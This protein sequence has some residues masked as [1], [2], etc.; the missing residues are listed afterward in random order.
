[1][2]ARLYSIHDS[3]V[4]IYLPPMAFRTHGEAERD[5]VSKVN[6]PDFGHLHKS[7]GNF[8]LFHVGTWDDESGVMTRAEHHEQILTGIQAKDAKQ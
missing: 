6:N 3:A 5:F 4:K 2:I 1:M 8:T 7:P